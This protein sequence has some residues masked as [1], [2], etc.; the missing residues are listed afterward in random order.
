MHS[1][2]ICVMFFSGKSD[3]GRCQLLFLVFCTYYLRFST[4][5]SKLPEFV[6]TD[7]DRPGFNH[8]MIRIRHLCAQEKRTVTISILIIFFQYG[9]RK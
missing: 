1:H 2:R 5:L 3:R 8:N 7:N 4:F 9:V 6:S